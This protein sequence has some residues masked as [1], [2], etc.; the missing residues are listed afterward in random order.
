MIMNQEAWRS[1]DGERFTLTQ[2]MICDCCLFCHANGEDGCL[3]DDT[4]RE[5]LPSGWPEGTTLTLGR[6]D[7]EEDDSAGFSWQSC[8]W[9]DTPLGGDRSYAVAWE[10]E[11]K[12]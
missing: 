11:V 1:R 6:L 5:G 3:D 10:P 4:C 9:C 2:I 12:S 8:E 7:G